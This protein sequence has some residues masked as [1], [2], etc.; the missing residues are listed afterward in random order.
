ML[1]WQAGDQSLGI[2]TIP[3]LAPGATTSVSVAHQFSSRGARGGF[4]QPCLKDTLTLTMRR[5]C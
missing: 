5:G 4:L 2:A 1:T 3:Q